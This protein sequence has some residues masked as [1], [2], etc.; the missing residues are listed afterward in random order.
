MGPRPNRPRLRRLRRAT[1]R[2]VVVTTSTPGR[3]RRRAVAT[4][5]PDC[6]NGAAP[7]RP[8]RRLV[9]D[10][11]D[12]AERSPRGD[13]RSARAVRLVEP[14]GEGTG[15]SPGHADA[16]APGPCAPVL[17]QADPTGAAAVLVRPRAGRD[18]V[19]RRDGPDVGGGAAGRIAAS[20]GRGY[21]P[22]ERRHPASLSD[23][24][25][26][27]GPRRARRG[28]TRQGGRATG[29]AVVRSRDAFKHEH[30]LINPRHGRGAERAAVI[31]ASR[32]QLNLPGHTVPLYVRWK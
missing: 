26:S 14:P 23:R 7:G 31:G 16:G 21:V 8:S 27:E 3:A 29:D 30:G 15:A 2:A 1:P 11:E 25:G 17:A 6:A 13:P 9:D 18:C 32:H 22:V 28:A 5:D 20:L 12:V 10:R 19:L 4:P 24:H